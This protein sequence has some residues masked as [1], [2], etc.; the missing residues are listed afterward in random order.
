MTARVL[1]LD[2]SLTRSALAS[3]HAGQEAIVQCIPTKPV[4][5]VA[6]IDRDKPVRYVRGNAHRYRH[7]ADHIATVARRGSMLDL[8]VVEGYAYSSDEIGNAERIELGGVVRDR[9]A[10]MAPMLEVA[11]STL[12]KFQ[13]GK[14]NADKITAVSQFSVECGAAFATH[15]EADAYALMLLGF[16]ILEP[17]LYVPRDKARRDVVKSLTEV[18][19][20][21][22]AT[23]AT[24][25]AA[26]H[27]SIRADTRSTDPARIAAARAE[28]QKALF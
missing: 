15:D 11:P 17:G 3:A 2:L 1:G 5:K 22:I 12:K 16:H 10:D 26:T 7:V 9:L 4:E 8:T 25:E 20:Q 6:V 14:G 18:T 27:P 23:F 24:R 21:M 13:C 19:L 28:Q